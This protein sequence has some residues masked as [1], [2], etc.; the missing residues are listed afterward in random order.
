[1]RTQ[2]SRAHLEYLPGR[3][4]MHLRRAALI[5]FLTGLVAVTA[6]GTAIAQSL[7]D[8]VPEGALL[9]VGWAGTDTPNTGYAG[10]HLEAVM[11]D[12][13]FRSVFNKV[14][15]QLMAKA[16]AGAEEQKNLDTAMAIAGPFWRHPSAIFVEPSGNEAVDDNPFRGGIICQAGAQ[17]K[18]LAKQL[19]DLIAQDPEAG[20]IFRVIEWGDLLAIVF[21]YRNA[22]QFPAA[23]AQALAGA[24]GFVA[25][26]KQTAASPFVS[27]YIDVDRLMSVIDTATAGAGADG[28]IWPKIR[29]AAGFKGFHRIALSGKFEGK[30]FA[31]NSFFDAP[32]PRQGLVKLFEGR[33]IE[34]EVLKSI[35]RTAGSA[36]VVRF[37]FAALVK[38]I[39]NIVAAVNEQ[40]V[41]TFDQVLGAGQMMIGKNP[42][43]DIL[44]PLGDTWVLFSDDSIA[45]NG[46]NGIIITNKLDDPVKA[47]QGLAALW[48]AAANA[49]NQRMQRAGSPIRFQQQKIGNLTIYSL[50]T[51]T[52]VPG[53]TISN[54]KLVIGFTP[55][56]ISK[57]AT[58]PP[59][60]QGLDQN[61]KYTALV[62]RLAP[63]GA[64][65]S[66]RFAD[67]PQTAPK[68]YDE[69]VQGLAMLRGMAQQQGIQLP[70]KILPSL[71]VIQANI[72]PAGEVSWTDATGFHTRGISPF[73]GSD[74]LGNAP[75]GTIT[76]VGTSSVLVAVL[77]P[78]LNRARETANR[79]KCA[80]NLR[81]I[82]QLILLYANEHQ[83]A[84]PPDLATLA[85]QEEL[86][87]EVYICP[88]GD[89]SVPADV[90]GM[91]R[92]QVAQ[93]IA[94]NSDYVYLGAGKSV[95]SPADDVLVYERP[96]DHRFDGI[97]VLFGD[98]H[99]SFV[100]IETAKQIIPNFDAAGR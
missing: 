83:G 59:P 23:G 22:P 36:Q 46:T 21:G 43:T 7:A 10:S 77:L 25:G 11:K 100:K 66:F 5:L 48:I 13:D 86:A 1:M 45:G 18:E 30:D 84:Y 37:D 35:P 29:D 65:T 28:Q 74:A 70:E 8:R 98:G 94:K 63:G 60:A 49:T 6:A 87:P 54:G 40:A 12:V 53:F 58:A 50:Q 88:S 80:A 9:Y 85:R 56:A 20:K 2:Y 71:E 16:G 81:Q 91:A 82:G 72:A 62:K 61:E 95:N 97:N 19:N 75:N 17:S 15:P 38:E 92:E 51:P 31:V 26:M 4:W 90:R 34:A 96:E 33:P 99:V 76:Q 78:S 55:D 27:V 47:N 14:V 73:P 41:Q 89:K 64:V 3:H 57:A 44:E 32:A 93:W 39:R 42:L 68:M 69:Y 52:V 67:L 24:P 79:V